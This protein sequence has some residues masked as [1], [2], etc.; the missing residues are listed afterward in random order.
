MRHIAPRQTPGMWEGRECRHRYTRLCTSWCSLKLSDGYKSVHQIII[1]LS[2]YVQTLLIKSKTLKKRKY[3]FKRL[4]SRN[5]KAE[6]PLSQPLSETQFLV[7]QNNGEQINTF[8]CFGNQGKTVMAQLNPRKF[9]KRKQIRTTNETSPP[10]PTSL[11]LSVTQ[12]FLS[13]LCGWLADT[14]G[15]HEPCLKNR[16]E[17]QL[18]KVMK[19]HV[20]L[21]IRNWNWKLP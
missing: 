20:Q 13:S 16:R 21:K 15:E 8:L 12:S 14:P 11:L 19:S 9:L 1:S 10:F 18:Q 17:N 7:L 6:R 3:F 5:S 4:K 2:V